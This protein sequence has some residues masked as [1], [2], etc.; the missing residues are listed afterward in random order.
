MKKRY[1]I[2]FMGTPEFAV[3]SFNK[4][5][6]EGHDVVAVV[7]QPDRKKGRGKSLAPSPV[8][9]AAIKSNIKVL[10]PERIRKKEAIDEI[11]LL[12]ADLFVTCA[13]GQI[14]PKRLLEIPPLGCINVHAS[15]LPKYRG[16]APIQRAIMNGEEVTGITTM[17]TDVGMDTGDILLK[18]EICIAEKATAGDLHDILMKEGA[19]LL[20][21][22]LD[23]LAEGNLKP[24]PQDDSKATYAPMIK[25][26]EGCVNWSLDSKEIYNRIR[27]F[28][29]WPGSFTSY[30][31][32][33]MKILAAGYNE[34]KHQLKP[35]TIIETKDQMLSIACGKGIIEIYRLQFENCKAMDISQCWHNMEAGEI[36][37]REN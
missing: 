10:Q 30:E 20:A 23:K 26:Q 9:K 24:I 11:A 6:E 12:E 34:K 17:M 22:T 5:I 25:K 13:Y 27:A 35:G 29:P 31:G 3:P 8:K 16:A 15:L 1:K 2:V 33:T 7:T 18:K 14:L 19:M 37:R 4:L 32:K 36:L 28:V 21:L